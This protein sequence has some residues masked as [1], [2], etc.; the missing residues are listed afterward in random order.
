M[1]KILVDNPLLLLFLIAALSDPLGRV[2]VKGTS[3][4]VAAVLFVSIAVNALNA[5]LKLPDVIF[6]LGAVLFVYTL[7]LSGGPGFFASFRSKGLR[8]SLFVIAVLI[9]AAGLATGA[10]FLL[11]LKPTLTAGMY[12][13]SLTNTPALAGVVQYVRNNAPAAARDALMAEPVIG[14]SIAYPM[15]VIAMIASILVVKRAWKV[16]YAV[17]ARQLQSLG[18]TSRQLINRTIHVNRTEP[19]D[20]TLVALSRRCGWDVNFGRLK[21]DGKLSLA[22]PGTRLLNRDLVSLVGAPEDVD[23]VTEYL[24]QESDEHLELDRSEFDYRRVFVSNPRVVGHRLG[25]I[26]L[27]QQYGA[28]ATRVRRGDVEML[29]HDDTVL[30]LGDRVRIVARREDMDTISRFFGDSYRALSEIDVL[31][32]S[33]GI[34]LGLLVGLIPIPLPGGLTFTLGFAGGPL[35]VA[36]ILGALGRTGPLVWSMPYSANLT[37]RQVGLIMFLAGVGTKA[38]HAFVST[39]AQ[40]GGVYLFAAGAVITTITALVTL[41]IGYRLLKI[42]LSLL[43]GLLAGLQTQPAVLGF[44]LEQTGN[45]LPNLGYASMFALAGIV[46]IILAQLLVAFLR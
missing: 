34:A 20:E 1:T 45:D 7:G 39:F 12:A 26:N 28:I 14:Y 13:G 30:E 19:I 32:F 22:E 43:M 16:D 36:L 27:P 21:R 6:N 38:G 2:K 46:K 8:D 41:W 40:G 23:R 15:G 25:E 10:H 44:A 24:G 5:D 9:V 33:L 37:L 3:L 4:G 31:T 17:E 35:V 29:A 18:G 42:P 11:H